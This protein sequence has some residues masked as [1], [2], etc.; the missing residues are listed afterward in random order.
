VVLG[1]MRGV[2][3]VWERFLGGDNVHFLYKYAAKV[4]LCL[5]WGKNASFGYL[6]VFG[7][8]LTFAAVILYLVYKQQLKRYNYEKKQSISFAGDDVGNGYRID[9]GYQGIRGR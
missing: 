6:Y 8:I 1:E 3:V 9:I 7:K 5:F 2:V 4:F